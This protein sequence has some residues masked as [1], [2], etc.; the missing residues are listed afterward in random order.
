MSLQVFDVECA[1]NWFMLLAR[2]TVTKRVYRWER[3]ND[4]EIG[5]PRKQLG[6]RFR[7]AINISFN[8]LAYDSWVIQAYRKGFDNHKIFRVSS[9]LINGDQLAQWTVAEHFGLEN[10]DYRHVDIA[11]VAPSIA[12]L[13]L[14]GGRLDA[15]KLQDLP[16]DP[17]QPV[18]EQLVTDSYT[19]CLNDLDLTERLFINLL[20]EIR[21]RKSMSKEYEMD[22]K[23]KSDPAIAEAVLKKQ[24]SDLGVPVLKGLVEPKSFYKYEVP[25]V[26]CYDTPMMRQALVDGMHRAHENSVKAIDAIPAL[27]IKTIP[28]ALDTYMGE[29]DVENL[30]AYMA[31]AIVNKFAVSDWLECKERNEKHKGIDISALE[32][33]LQKPMRYLL[34]QELN[35]DAVKDYLKS[36]DPKVAASVIAQSLSFRPYVKDIDEN[37]DADLTKYVSHIVKGGK[38]KGKKLKTPEMCAALANVLLAKFRLS[39]KGS[40]LVPPELRKRINYED[41]SYQMGSGGLH[42]CEKSRVLE[43]DEDEVLCDLDVQ[44]YYPSMIIE[45]GFSP[46]ALGDKF[47][48]VY[49]DIYKRRIEGKKSGNKVVADSLKIV[50]NSSFG[51]CALAA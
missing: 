2:D 22:L 17:E 40:M 10:P 16:F 8:G 25:D 1:P 7:S 39:E 47:T 29:L 33:A 48:E 50:L 3:L 32:S 51:A 49:S 14:Y 36:Y 20:P 9:Y 12:S 18:S 28:K 6:T 41:A 34:Y 42:S 37:P 27:I 35:K 30:C 31:K 15:P 44:S 11:P 5:L 13:K 46:E 4:V 43:V 24:I 45:Y 23:S 38:R 26:F 19:Y 21:L